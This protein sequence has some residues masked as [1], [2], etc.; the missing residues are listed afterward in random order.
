LNPGQKVCPADSC[1]LVLLGLNRGRG[2]NAH[3]L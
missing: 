2:L 1:Y 3:N